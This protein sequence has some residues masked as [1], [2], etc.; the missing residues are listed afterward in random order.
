M[1]DQTTSNKPEQDLSSEQETATSEVEVPRIELSDLVDCV[2]VIDLCSTRGAFKGAELEAIGTLRK[3]LIVFVNHNA[4][5][6]ETTEK[7]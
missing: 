3:R 2:K 1:K 5:D 6:Q 7:E 4:P